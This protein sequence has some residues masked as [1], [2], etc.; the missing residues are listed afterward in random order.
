MDEPLLGNDGG[1]DV[2]GGGTAADK[3]GLPSWL[4]P[5]NDEDHRSLMSSEHDA[6]AARTS[7]SSWADDPLPAAAGGRGG[8]GGHARHQSELPRLILGVRIVNI[9]AAIA[10]I[11]CSVSDLLPLF[12]DMFLILVHVWRFAL[13][14]ISCSWLTLARVHAYV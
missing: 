12:V 11:T 9:G 2:G 10:L 5:E 1:G 6:S 13:K 4:D 8:G 7:S 14:R 3:S